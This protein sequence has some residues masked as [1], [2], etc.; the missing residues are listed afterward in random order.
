MDQNNIYVCYQMKLMYSIVDTNTNWRKPVSETCRI[1]SYDCAPS[2][3]KIDFQSEENNKFWCHSISVQMLVYQF[4]L[5]MRIILYVFGHFVVE[6]MQP[7]TLVESR[8]VFSVF[9][10]AHLIES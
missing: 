6:S 1:R 7:R 2:F 9:G 4:K 8:Y 3:S 10:A 5:N